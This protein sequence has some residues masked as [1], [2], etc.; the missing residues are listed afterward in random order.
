MQTTPRFRVLLGGHQRI[1]ALSTSSTAET[2]AICA[3]T[4][5]AQSR[6]AGGAHQVDP[7]RPRISPCSKLPR[8]TTTVRC[9]AR[10]PQLKDPHPLVVRCP[11][12][13]PLLALPAERQHIQPRGAG[14]P[15]RGRRGV[16]AYAPWIYFGPKNRSV[17]SLVFLCVFCL[18]KLRSLID[19]FIL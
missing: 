4:T 9:P 15:R 16:H 5:G 10:T 2:G 14:G 8:A 7:R 19:H 3:T 11:P 18:N 17:R 13:D 12:P 6:G 1:P